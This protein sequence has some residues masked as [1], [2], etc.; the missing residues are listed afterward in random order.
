MPEG[1]QGKTVKQ[2]TVQSTQTPQGPSLQ[3]LSSREEGVMGVN[4][5]C[6]PSCEFPWRKDTAEG[7]VRSVRACVDA[8]ANGVVLTPALLSI[9]F[10]TPGKFYA[11]FCLGFFICK[12]GRM[13]S[14]AS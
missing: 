13:V 10:V 11:S 12:M 7:R 3:A 8:E 2:S 1:L 9:A 6:L 4:L 14:T 5:D